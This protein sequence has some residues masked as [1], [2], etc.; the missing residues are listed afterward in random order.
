MASGRAA[1]RALML[2]H[3]APDKLLERLSKA[4]ATELENGHFI[5]ALIA[6]VDSATHRI[7]FANAG[8]A[9]AEHY[10]PTTDCFAPLASTAMPI[11]VGDDGCF[12]AGPG[13][14]LL[15]G[16]LIVLC[17]DGIIEA[18]DAHDQPF[19]MDRLKQLVRQ[20]RD[21]PLDEL[22]GQIATRVHEHHA[23][24]LPS[25]DV[26]ILAVRRKK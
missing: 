22:V 10:C 13:F 1:L 7:E 2:E 26:T 16:D 8:H 4:I 9:P 12:A 15:P 21:A 3:C 18:L 23:G 25:D 19:G 24:E 6:C 14:A 20:H 5:T 11:G 17:T